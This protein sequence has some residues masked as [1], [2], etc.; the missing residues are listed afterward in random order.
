MDKMDYYNNERIAIR[1]ELHNLKA[2]QNNFLITAITTT[3]LILGIAATFLRNTP[4]VPA[5]V[6]LLPLSVVIPLWWMFFDKAKTVSRCV[7]YHRILEMLLLKNHEAKNYK[8]WERSLG[9][10][11]EKRD[12]F[13]DEK[14]YASKNKISLSKILILMPSNR[15]WMLAYYTFFGLSIL[16]VGAYLAQQKPVSYFLEHEMILTLL[17]I[18]SVLLLIT[19]VANFRAV[20]N[21]MNNENS[22]DANEKMWM[23]LLDVIE[24]GS[25]LD[26]RKNLNP[27]PPNGR[28][29][30]AMLLANY[31]RFQ[32]ENNR[33]WPRNI[34]RQH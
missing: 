5:V 4:T 9:E 25:S 11:R 22:Y 3:G 20:N 24:I 27:K 30:R 17:I 6:L 1:Q 28:E 14:E 15:Y 21:L 34:R 19:I 29:R 26:K 12:V 23:E 2:C 31:S 18:T 7:G 32:I 13:N 10:L 33:K 16:C 8:G